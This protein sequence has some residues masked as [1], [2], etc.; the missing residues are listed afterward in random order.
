MARTVEDCALML[1]VMTIEYCQQYVCDKYFIA[2]ESQNGISLQLH[3]I[4][5]KIIQAYNFVSFAF[6]EESS[7][8]YRVMEQFCPITI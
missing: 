8:K 6:F 2:C 5:N 7:F 1:E 3:A 4:L